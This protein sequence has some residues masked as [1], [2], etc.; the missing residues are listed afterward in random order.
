M[1]SSWE[2]AQWPAGGL[3][4]RARWRVSPIYAGAAV[5]EAGARQGAVEPRLETSWT[6][7]S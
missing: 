3:K 6:W 5:G 7:R 4:H 2:Q 1:I